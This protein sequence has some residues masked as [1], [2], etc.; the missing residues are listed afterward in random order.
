[1]TNGSLVKM[2]KGKFTRKF[3]VFEDGTAKEYAKDGI[4]DVTCAFSTLYALLQINGWE[5][6]A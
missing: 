5:E 3:W 1:M 6:I 2:R 4:W